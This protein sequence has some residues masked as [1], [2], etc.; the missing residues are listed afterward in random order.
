MVE[1]HII[2]LVMAEFKISTIDDSPTCAKFNSENFLSLTRKQRKEIFM[3]E[4][5]KLVENYVYFF[6]HNER[7]IE[8]DHIL[9][10]AKE[11][12]SLGMLYMEFCDS[13][14]EGDGLRILRCWKY[15]MLLFKATNKYKYAVQASR[16]LFQYYFTFTERMKHQL[17]WSRCVNV[18]GRRGRNVSMDL[19]MEHLNRYLKGALSHIGSNVRDV[20]FNRIGRSLRKIMDITENYD[21]CAKIQHE[22]GYHSFKP[23]NKDLKLVVDDLNTAKVFVKSTVKR[24]HKQFRNFKGNTARKIEEEE[25]I[26]WMEDKYQ[27][28]IRYG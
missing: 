10:Y 17:L 3:R 27:K 28:L 9:S 24:E 8:S 19:H 26:E 7:P 25:L 21:S 6:K 14:H 4:M 20:T 16:L 12:L 22:F 11:T 1:G 2:S 23:A 18:H 13:I 15:M 5:L